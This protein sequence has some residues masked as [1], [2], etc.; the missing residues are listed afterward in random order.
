MNKGL[1]SITRHPNYFGEILIWA[2]LYITGVTLFVSSNVSPVFY[3]ILVISPIIMALV[4][5]KISTP[6]LEKHMEKYDGWEDYKKE[7][8]MIFPWGPTE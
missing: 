4:L 8:P 2:G 1:W 3:G 5:M 6:L 7:T